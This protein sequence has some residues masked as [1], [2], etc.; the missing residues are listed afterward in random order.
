MKKNITLAFIFLSLLSYSI[1]TS[2]FTLS[3]AWQSA[4]SY[5]ADYTAAQY[6][7]NAEL[8]QGKQARSTLLPQVS[9]NV[10]YQRQPPSKL[11]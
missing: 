4:L 7:R 1:S 8:E 3:E 9:A 2:A 10:T 11:V 5:S 6:R